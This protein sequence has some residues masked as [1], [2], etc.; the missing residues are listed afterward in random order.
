VN[1]KHDKSK[2]LHAERYVIEPMLLLVLGFFAMGFGWWR[3]KFCRFWKDWW[4]GMAG[5]FLGEPLS[6]WGIVLF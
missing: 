6:T 2:Q 4:L 5:L 1:G 3:L